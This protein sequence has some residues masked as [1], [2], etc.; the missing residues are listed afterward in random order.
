M[1]QVRKL[2]DFYSSA[3]VLSLQIPFLHLS[4]VQCPEVHSIQH[5]DVSESGCKMSVTNLSKLK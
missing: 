2:M 3:E 5:Q 4:A 1:N